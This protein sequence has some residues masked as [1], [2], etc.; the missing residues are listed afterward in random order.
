MAAPGREGV[1]AGPHPVP[2]DARRHRPQLPGGARLPRPAGRRARRSSSSWPRCRS[3][4][5]RV[6]WSRRPGRGPAATGCRPS[7]CSTPSRSTGFDAVFGGGRRDEEKA[8]AKERVFSFRDDFGQWDPKNQRPELWNLYNGRHRKGEHIRVF[9]L[10]NWTELDIWQYIEDDDIEMPSIYYAHRREVFRRDGMLARGLAVRHPDGRRGAGRDDGALPHGRRRV[11]HRRGRVAG[12]D[13]RRGHRR[14]RP[15]RASPS[16]ARPGPTTSSPRPPWKTASARGTSSM[17]EMLRFAT[18]GSVDDGKSTLIGRLLLDTKQIFEDQLEAVER[19]QPR[20]RVRL[21]QPRPAHRRPARRARAGHH[22]RRRV[23]LLR[24]AA[25]ASS[26]SPTRP[27]TCS[28]RATWSRARRRPTSRSCSST[29]ARA[30]S[31]SR[32]ATRSSRRCC[33]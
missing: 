8:R 33:R 11:L 15:R 22:H 10:S 9:P 17:A 31:S 18:A 29:P 21:H 4:S 24:D 23:P 2:A 19:T 13:R 1:L 26:S 14:G 12:G 20:P 25:S 16:G 3:R 28:T 30:C 5:T 27:G 6:A 32:A 7:R